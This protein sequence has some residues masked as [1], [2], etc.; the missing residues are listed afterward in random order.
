MD[1]HLAPLLERIATRLTSAR[2]TL[3]GSLASGIAHGLS[4]AAD[5]VPGP[6]WTPRTTCL[7]L[8]DIDDLVALDTR[9][10]GAGLA[11]QRTH[12]LPRVHPARAQGL[13]GLLHP[14]HLSHS[15]FSGSPAL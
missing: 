5:V 7:T 2:R 12:L 14:H 15:T 4:R 13:H 9:P 8:F 3:W 1:A 10:T 11:V 6:P